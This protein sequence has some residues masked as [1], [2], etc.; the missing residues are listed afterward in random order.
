M[1]GFKIP[2][3]GR[4]ISLTAEV[5]AHS[6]SLYMSNVSLESVAVANNIKREA[7][8]SIELFDDAIR[9][10]VNEFYEFSAVYRENNAGKFIE[11]VRTL[12]NLLTDSGRKYTDSIRWTDDEKYV[13][14]LRKPVSSAYL[15]IF[16]E[17][18]PNRQVTPTDFWKCLDLDELRN[19]IYRSPN[20][21]NVSTIFTRDKS[22]DKVNKL[23]ELLTELRLNCV[24]LS[25][26]Y[27]ATISA[28][29]ERLIRG[30]SIPMTDT[31]DFE[32]N[33][34]VVLGHVIDASIVKSINKKWYGREIVTSIGSMSSDTKLLLDEPLQLCS[35]ENSDNPKAVDNLFQYSKTE[36][37]TDNIRLLQREFLSIVEQIDL[38][39]RRLSKLAD[40]LSEIPDYNGNGGYNYTLRDITV[41]MHVYSGTLTELLKF[42]VK[43]A[44]MLENSFTEVSTLA[45]KVKALK[46][47]IDNYVAKRLKT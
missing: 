4:L 10:A 13:T 38:S 6:P 42:V 30:E 39:S 41:L 1:K 8:F 32:S 45:N 46:S 18:D 40:G 27:E 43:I 22:F 21:Q 17:Q 34:S 37:A 20:F 2:N 15:M 29:M 19:E 36:H 33:Q 12:D 9:D 3:I 26:N 11:D 47:A 25:T 23:L 14:E 7:G 16:G 5:G 35:P 28:V 31:I 44:V 24:E